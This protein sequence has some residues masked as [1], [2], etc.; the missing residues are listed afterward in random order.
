[1]TYY[2]QLETIKQLQ[3]IIDG[4]NNIVFLGGAGVSTESGIKDFRGKSG[5]YSMQKKQKKMKLQPVVDKLK[6]L[7]GGVQLIKNIE[8]ACKKEMRA[9]YITNLGGTK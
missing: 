2:S 1:M 7:V 3:S 8:L 9:H 4:S 5:L 6:S